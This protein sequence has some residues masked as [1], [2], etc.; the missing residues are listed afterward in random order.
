MFE[1]K[2]IIMETIGRNSESNK[3]LSAEMTSIVKNKSNNY[4]IAK[5]VPIND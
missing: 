4:F 5:K 2:Y 3:R 1:S